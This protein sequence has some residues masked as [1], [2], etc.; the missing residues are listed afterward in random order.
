[1]NTQDEQ[2]LRRQLEGL[3]EIYPS[4]QC[5]GRGVL[6]S[7]IGFCDH[8]PELRFPVDFHW[9]ELTVEDLKAMPIIQND[10][11][12]ALVAT[13]LFVADQDG[14]EL[15]VPRS[16]AE[17]QSARYLPKG[18][19]EARKWCLRRN[20]ELLNQCG[21]AVDHGSVQKRSF[22]YRQLLSANNW[23]GGHGYES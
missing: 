19:L 10:P 13:R 17:L 22:F 7:F 5:E 11:L 12:S 18:H 16:E 14:G 23:S 4:I 3:R 1:V 15:P 21:R 6:R 9:E 2:D 8:H 20:A